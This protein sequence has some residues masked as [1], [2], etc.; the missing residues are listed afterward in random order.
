[1]LRRW[2]LHEALINMLV[3]NLLHYSLAVIAVIMAAGQVGINAT[4]ALG[5]IGVVGIALGFT[6]QDTLSNVIAGFLIFIDRPFRVGDW[7]TVAEQSGKV[8][9]ITMRTTWLRTLNNTW[10]IIPNKAIIHEVMVNHSK[11][12]PTRRSIESPPAA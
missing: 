6:A 10:V 9:E 1:M 5:G 8:S 11:R 3:D 12:G 7:V 2:G 4:A